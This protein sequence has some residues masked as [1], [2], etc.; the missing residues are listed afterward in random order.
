V[1]RIGEGYFETMGIPLLRGRDFD[2]DD[3]AGAEGVTI[4]AKPLAERMFPGADPLGKRITFA[5]GDDAERT[6][7]IVGVSS[8]FPTSQMSTNRAQLLLP[9]AQYRDVMRDSVRA[10]DDLGGG[11][12]LMLVARSVPGE[13]AN[14]MTA[15]LDT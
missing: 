6:L 5:A 1:T 4:I 3:V 12:H 9:L 15:A 2:D 8:D 7:T 13:P 11:A 10:N 14:K